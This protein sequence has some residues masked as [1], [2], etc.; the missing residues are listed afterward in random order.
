MARYSLV[1]LKVLLKTSQTNKLGKLSRNGLQS[2]YPKL[3]AFPAD[4]TNC[5]EIV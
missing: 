1:V 5:C 4:H 3:T 2:S